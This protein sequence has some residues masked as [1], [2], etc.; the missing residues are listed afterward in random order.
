M[1]K[2]IADS[3]A[4][5]TKIYN[6]KSCPKRSSRKEDPIISK[7]LIAKSISSIDISKTIIFLRLTTIPIIPIRK[8]LS[9]KDKKVKNCVVIIVKRERDS[10]SRVITLLISNQTP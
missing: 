3:E 6:A 1:D 8:R 5:T 2:P 4:A 7:K 10:N 9:A